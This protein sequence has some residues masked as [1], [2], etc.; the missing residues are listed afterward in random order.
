MFAK[1]L[2]GVGVLC[3]AVAVVLGMSTAA[4]SGMV[5]VAVAQLEAMIASLKKAVAKK[6][7]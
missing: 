5:T 3:L 4:I 6:I 7:V 1:I 2:T